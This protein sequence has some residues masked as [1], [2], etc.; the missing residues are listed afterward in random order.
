MMLGLKESTVATVVV[1][2]DKDFLE[3]LADLTKRVEELDERI[4]AHGREL[5]RLRVDV[6]F[7]NT[8]V[9]EFVPEEEETN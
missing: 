9:L 6:E 3:E 5:D 1:K 2:M 8:V 7:W 4:E